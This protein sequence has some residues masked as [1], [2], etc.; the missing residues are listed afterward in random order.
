MGH[1][2]ELK[3]KAKLRELRQMLVSMAPKSESRD[4]KPRS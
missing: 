2:N 1:A 3:V 4:D